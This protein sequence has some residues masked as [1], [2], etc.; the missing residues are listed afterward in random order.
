MEHHFEPVTG[1]FDE[2]GVFTKY[3]VGAIFTALVVGGIPQ[4]PEI[5]ESWLR[6]RIL[7]GDQEL[8][9]MLRKTLADLNIEIAEDATREE[10]IEAAKNI[11]AARNGNTFRRNGCGLALAAYNVKAMLKEATAILYPG[12]NG[13]HKWGATKKSPKSLL[14]ERVF[15]DDYLIPLGK[16]EPDGTMIQVGHPDTPQGKRATLTYYDY[17]VQPGI[18]FTVSSSEDIITR[19]QWERIL[20]QGQRLGMGALRSMGYGQFKITDFAPV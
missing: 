3:R 1:I 18:S 19:E 12:G 13:G 10:I 9:I 8:A 17:C 5:I 2:S 7:G 6:Q 14:A 15:V 4:K 11:A 20:V 16:E